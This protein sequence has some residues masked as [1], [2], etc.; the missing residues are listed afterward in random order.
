MCEKD[1]TEADGDVMVKGSPPRVRE[2]PALI[3]LSAI[4]IGITPARVG[5]TTQLSETVTRH[6]DYPRVCGKDVQ[7]SIQHILQLGSPPHV[8]EGLSLFLMKMERFRITP[9]RAGRTYF[10]GLVDGKD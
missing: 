3:V 8:R 9:A 2:G 1:L 10:Q 5:R 7:V 4:V 6:W